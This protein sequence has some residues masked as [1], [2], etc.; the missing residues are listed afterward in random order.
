MRDFS[1]NDGL[2]IQYVEELDETKV[3]DLASKLLNDRMDPLVLLDL[4]NEGM[5]RVGQLYESK[6]YYIADLIMAGLIFKQV[7][8]LDEMT[9]HF[10]NKYSKKI[11]RVILGTVKGDIHDI[12]K[13]IF[14]GMIEANG[15]EV[16]DL[17]V[18][19]PKELFLKKVEELKPDIVGL[20]GVL[21]NTVEPMKDVIEAAI[22]AGLRDKVRFIV[23]GNHL[24]EEISR[25]IGADNFAK[26][27]STGVKICRQWI[28][29]KKG[30][31]ATDD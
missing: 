28:D 6:Q 17:G 1:K 29:C 13:D 10:Q 25:F 15:F 27:A 22:E 21:T 26:D 18:D 16:I 23:G 24:T 11:G 4:L 2:L 31:G 14:R 20:S 19:V 12:G 9:A 7:L 30:Q 5:N 3:L 8:E